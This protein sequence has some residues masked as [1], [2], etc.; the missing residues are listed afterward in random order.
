MTLITIL[1]EPAVL[2]VEVTHQRHHRQP[3]LVRTGKLVQQIPEEEVAGAIQALEEEDTTAQVADSLPEAAVYLPEAVVYHLEEAVSSLAADPEG[4]ETSSALLACATPVSARM[5]RRAL[6]FAFTA[7]GL[8]V[9]AIKV[10]EEAPADQEV[11]QEE[12]QE[13]AAKEV[14]AAAVF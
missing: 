10:V 7:G 12:W 6:R 1:R 14:Q 11:Q 4:E 9:F 13:V 8:L 3:T 2:E 5:D